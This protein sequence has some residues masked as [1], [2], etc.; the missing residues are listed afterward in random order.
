M[1]LSTRYLGLELD[2]PLM[3]GASPLVE[4]LD[5]VK[6]AEDAGASAIVM[7]SLFEE[8]LRGPDDGGFYPADRSQFSFGPAEYL[9]QIRKLKATLGIPVIG[10]LNG[11]TD[12]SW[13]EHARLMDQAG[14]DALELNTYRVCT[15]FER[16]ATSLEDEVVEMV[17]HVVASTTIPV[18]VKLSPFYTSLPHFAARLVDAGAKG[19]VLFNRFYQPDV[20]SARREV[21]PGL[22]Y[23]TS[24]E[25]LL[26]LAWLAILSA[27]L[28]TTLA[29]T[30]GVHS[31]E[32]AIKAILTGANGVQL[33]SEV[34]Q[35]GL[36][37][38][39]KLRTQISEWLSERDYHSLAQVQGSMNFAR[40]PDAGELSRANYLHVLHSYPSIREW[41]I[42]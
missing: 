25:L 21:E 34:L 29:V 12:A 11:S 22:E 16:S 31:S 10:S 17:R 28:E 42:R 6:L 37:R 40:S 15:D 39:R 14:A 36:V 33:V 19:L 3:L 13:L 35:H 41:S 7:C 20:D 32:D 38:F 2:S 5:T 9:E 27:R 23:S 1:D 4:D 24:N 8:Q 30:G 18:A 26:R